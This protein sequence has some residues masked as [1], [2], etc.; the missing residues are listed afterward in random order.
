MTQREKSS[1]QRIQE[2]LAEAWSL[3]NS[4]N[5]IAAADR[6]ELTVRTTRMNVRAL[7]AFA[8]VCREIG[9][10]N[11]A[12]AYLDPAV[13]LS[14]PPPILLIEWGLTLQ[15]AARWAEAE[16][17]FRRAIAEQPGLAR[18]WMCLAQLCLDRYDPAGALAAVSGAESA[19]AQGADVKHLRGLAL[20]KAGRAEEAVAALQEAMTL[21]PQSAEV[22]CNLAAALRLAG[23]DLRAL[24]L[25]EK[26]S[27][28]RPG[29]VR[30]AAARIQILESRKQTAEAIALLEATLASGI[31]SPE[32]ALAQARLA[33]KTGSVASAVAK[34]EEAISRPQTRQQSR[35]LLYLTLGDLLE[36]EG[37]NQEAFAAYEAGNRLAPRTF[38][39]SAFLRQHEEIKQ[40]FA[41]RTL[42]F[43]T[44]S[45]PTN[46]PVFIVGMPRSGTTLV[47]Q[48]LASHP[49]VYGAGELSEIGRMLRSLQQ[50]FGFRDKYPGCVLDL[51]REHLDTLAAEH[52]DRLM[53]LAA[54]KGGP[55]A[56]KRVTDK[57]PGNYFNVGFVG[58][59]YPQCH[60]IHCVRNA[61]DTCLSCYATP[62]TAGHGW[63]NDLN[64]LAVAHK[65]KDDLMAFWRQSTSIPILDVVYEE[66]VAGPERVIHKMLEFLELPWNEACMAHHRT[67]RV[68]H[69]A[70][71]D[72]A[73]QPI[74][75]S[76]IGR[77]K[78]FR[79]ELAPLHTALGL[80]ADAS[81]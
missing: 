59:L 11:R 47:E 36:E 54:Q 45:S 63:S 8:A 35:S 58:M 14:A 27:S 6:L 42:P 57:M 34:I 52:M 75:K 16:A 33:R 55:E 71:R 17:T 19:G 61:M 31:V 20:L 46:L 80:P 25:L 43:V 1:E 73:R 26:A 24:E 53:R 50:R 51:R 12:L 74:Y 22:L 65:A 29:W 66:L 62:L 68:I 64:S 77:W 76:S 13:R 78:K 21:Q 5:P 44:S 4:G 2:S 18:G 48:I 10:P 81:D 39:A 40:V 67:E 32:L 15:A 79:S 60:V 9:E 7:A 70:S 38:D 3:Y 72:Q 49:A 23:D 69:T 56:I 28:L 41:A 37:R 30:P